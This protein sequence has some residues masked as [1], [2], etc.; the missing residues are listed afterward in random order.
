MAL[1]QR[2]QKDDAPEKRWRSDAHRRFVT[3]QF[4]CAACG[5]NE[6][7][8]AAHVSMGSEPGMGLKTDDWRVVPLC[9]TT[10]AGE[11]CHQRQHR[12]GEQTFWRDYEAKIG[13]SVEDLISSLCKSSPK[14]REIEQAKRV[15][16]NG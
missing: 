10:I 1:P 7:I 15:R 9:G 2:K 13:Q 12:V 3:G 11:G 5:A 8:Q 16:S 6:P 4:R 14:S